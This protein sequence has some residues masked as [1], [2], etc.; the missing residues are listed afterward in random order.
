LAVVALLVG[1][2]STTTTVTE[3]ELDAEDPEFATVVE[4]SPTTTPA[5][6]PVAAPAAEVIVYERPVDEVL[7]IFVSDVDGAN[8][9]QLTSE[10]IDS[11]QVS[12]SGD[13]THMAFARDGNLYLMAI[14]GGGLEQVT[15]TDAF[16]ALPALS[17]DGS[18]LVFT[19]AAAGA[20]LVLLDLDTDEEEKLVANVNAFGAAWSPDGTRV[21]FHGDLEVASDET[22]LFVVDVAT[23][24]TE[25]LT[26][27]DESRFATWS[28]DSSMIAFHRISTETDRAGRF[29][30]N[31]WVLDVAT[32]E[33]RVLIDH[34]DLDR[35]PSW[36]ASGEIAFFRDGPAVN[37]LQI[38]IFDPETGEVTPTG[39]NGSRPSW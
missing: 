26:A 8:E 39:I 2:C 32:G 28:P 9:R 17:P 11:G 30:R 12:L 18:Q 3:Q 5:A 16:D 37:D 35:S 25:Q 4:E 1:A 29:A 23:G 19:R 10:P 33:E 34:P 7:Q 22:A 38:M 20:E 36:T 31:I 15:N 13:R 21:A 14:D 27:F 6:T 24:E